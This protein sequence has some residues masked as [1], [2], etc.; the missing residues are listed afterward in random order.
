MVSENQVP[1]QGEQQFFWDFTNTSLQ[2]WWVENF[3]MGKNGAVRKRA[4]NF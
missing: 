3:F 1:W 2:D 4:F